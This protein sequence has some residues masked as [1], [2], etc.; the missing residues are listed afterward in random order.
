MKL[1][2]FIFVW[3]FYA[4]TLFAQKSFV[5]NHN[6]TDLSQIPDNWI[7]SAKKDLKIIYFR[8]SHGSH[9]DVGGMAALRRYSA[10]YAD[11]YNYN[12]TGGSGVLKLMTQWHSVDFEPDTWY[13]ITRTFLDD[14]ANADINVVMWAWS[15]KFYISDVQAYID[16][17]ETFIADYGPN[18]TKIQSGTRTVPVTFI[19]QTATSQASDAA[20]K[21]V[22]DQNQLIRQHCNDN[23]R[24]LFDFNDIETYNP[25]GQYFGDGNPDGSY[26]G[27]KRLDDDISYNLNGGGRGNWGIEWNN[28]NPGSELAQLSV[29]DICTVCE[30]SDQRENPDEDNSRLHCVLKGR[31]AWWMWAK[32]AGWGER[33][34]QINT[35]SVLTEENLNGQQLSLALSGESFADTALAIS[36]FSLN[37]VPLGTSIS[38]VNYID[39]THATL[40]LA[41]D[42]TDFDTDISNFSISISADELAGTTNI[43]SNTISINAFDEQLNIASDNYLIEKNLDIEKINLSLSDTYF[44]D[45]QLDIDNFTLNNAPSGLSIESV[46]YTD[47]V[48]AVLN[49]AFDGTDFDVDITDFSITISNQELSCVQNLNSNTLNIEAIDEEAPYLSLSVEI[50]LSEDNLDGANVELLLHNDTFVDNQL[51]IDNFELINPPQGCSVQQINYLSDTTASCILSFNGTD[52]DENIIDF[53]IRIL[54]AELK[55]NQNLD[56]DYLTIYAIIESDEQPEAF[57]QSNDTLTEDNLNNASLNIYL[58]AAN[59]SSRISKSDFILNNA[60]SGLSILSVSAVNDTSTNITLAFDGTDFSNNFDDFNV[61]VLASGNSS[62]ADITTNSLTIFAS[63]TVTFIE[64]I[65]GL[66]SV[67]L[68]PNPNSGDFTLSLT[69]EKSQDYSVKIIDESGK[70]Y[71]Y[72]YFSGKKGENISNINMPGYKSGLKF[73]IITMENRQI[74]IPFIVH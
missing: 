39:V 15:S 42:G 69:L 64:H 54:A 18:G 68:F 30:H 73:L 19:F 45:N 50:D 1:N 67:N 65:N 40:N 35:A 43:E 27:L 49:L 56:G 52:F 74:S 26:S 4:G 51:A 46:Q 33:S 34:L 72:S 24:I 20:N 58:H 17:M 37:N 61:T 55:G 2:I 47:S 5:I 66:A 13:S 10:T 9:I 32:L 16:T 25:D 36:N 6:H 11:K 70:S 62:N 57:L 59:F 14:P 48:N 60:P 71:F 29:D 41:F 21:I 38:S 8:R 7:D 22:Y 23:N 63:S 12:T 44:V 28:A 53:N 31:A 3:V